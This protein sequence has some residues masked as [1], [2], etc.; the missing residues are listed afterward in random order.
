[1]LLGLHPGP[2]I[3]VAAAASLA[4]V[5]PSRARTLLTELTR[6]HLVAEPAPGRYALHDLLR[7]YA[8]ELA[9]AQECPADR[10]AAVQ[11][12]LDHYL[13]TA[14]NAAAHIDTCQ[15][16]ELDGPIPGAM[17]GEHAAAE[18][19]LRG[20]DDERATLLAAV[21]LAADVGLDAHCWRLAWTLT[22]FLGRRGLSQDQIS[23][24]QTGLAAARRSSDVTGQA[25]A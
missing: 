1:R 15:S 13:H 24:L 14:S 8:G 18:A 9:S 16:M 10:D 12:L 2:D 6:A 23:T 3:P 11:R 20:S 21:Y 7:A 17:G 4:A 5:P 22:T 19:V 25:H